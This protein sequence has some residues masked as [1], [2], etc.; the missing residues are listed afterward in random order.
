MLASPQVTT[1]NG[2]LHGVCDRLLHHPDWWKHC[3]CPTP[4]TGWH[5][6][7]DHP[8]NAAH[9]DTVCMSVTTP[10]DP[11]HT[12]LVGVPTGE[13]RFGK[14]YNESVQQNCTAPGILQPRW[15]CQ[16]TSQKTCRMGWDMVQGCEKDAWLSSFVLEATG[17]RY[18]RDFVCLIPAIGTAHSCVWHSYPWCVLNDCDMYPMCFILCA[19]NDQK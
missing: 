6:C 16:D 9:T 19:T 1:L 8:A 18:A 11:F 10:G 15:W 2:F 12:C 5:K 17:T 14:L 7:M 4:Y 13:K 3:E